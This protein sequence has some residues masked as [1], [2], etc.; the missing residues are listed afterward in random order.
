MILVRKVIRV[1]NSMMI[2]LPGR[3]ELPDALYVYTD[4]VY[5]LYSPIGNLE[6]EYGLRVIGVVRPMR[7]RYRTRS[8]KYNHLNLVTVP[9]DATKRTKLKFG[10]TVVVL[11]TQVYDEPAMLVVTATRIVEEYI[12]KAV[13]I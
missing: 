13:R 3:L 5:V 4:N 12:L 6:A 11:L 9:K 7:K 1:G 10:D 8:G 2:S